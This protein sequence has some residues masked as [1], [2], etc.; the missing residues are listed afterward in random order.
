MPIDKKLRNRLIQAARKISYGH[1]PRKTQKNKQKIDA[2]LF[3]CSKCG[4]LCYEGTSSD[5]FE[6]YLEQHENVIWEKGDM[7]HIIPVID[8]I[9]GWESF[10]IFYERLFSPEDNWRYLCKMCHNSKTAEENRFRQNEK[11]SKIRKK[12]EKKVDT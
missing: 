6:K 12:R 8:P 4:V 2:N 1:P 11:L 7:D 9:K 5:N 3:Q 10:D